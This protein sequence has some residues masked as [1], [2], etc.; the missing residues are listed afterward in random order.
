MFLFV[1]REI[2]YHLL[3][4]DDVK[5]QRNAATCLSGAVPWHNALMCARHSRI[6]PGTQPSSWRECAHELGHLHNKMSA[7][8]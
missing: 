6:T 1:K 7:S 4:M 5:T 2:K 3:L 8:L